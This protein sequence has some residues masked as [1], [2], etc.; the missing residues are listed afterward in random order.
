MTIKEKI[1]FLLD[2]L[3]TESKIPSAYTPVIKSL[4]TNYLKSANDD[5][6]KN[7]LSQL[8]TELIPWLLE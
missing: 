8:N 3:L 5:D 2:K 1:K 4:V 7:Y 6:L